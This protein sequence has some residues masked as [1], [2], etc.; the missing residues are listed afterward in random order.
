MTSMISATRTG[1][2]SLSPLEK[3]IATARAVFPQAQAIQSMTP[4]GDAKEVWRRL[5]LAAKVDDWALA[6]NLGRELGLPVAETLSAKPSA[7]SLVP[8][9]L[10][11]KSL[12]LPLEEREHTLV[13]ATGLPFP[14]DVLDAVRFA[15]GRTIECMLAPPE[16]IEL[17]VHSA[18]SGKIDKA[19]SELLIPESKI[20][21]AHV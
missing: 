10:A 12:I 21:R 11:R 1:L 18:Y 5:A 9:A 7:L 20:G 3:L 14:G 13:V 2:G 17:A 6:R 19:T 4:T 8:A 16:Y 15:S